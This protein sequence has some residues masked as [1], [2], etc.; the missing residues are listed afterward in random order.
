MANLLINDPNYAWLKELDLQSRNDGVYFGKWG[1]SGEVITTTSPA[2]N[3]P[4]AEVCSS[5]DFK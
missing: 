3:K 2:N 5:S 4:I 1:G